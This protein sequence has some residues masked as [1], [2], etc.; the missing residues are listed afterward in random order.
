MS[1]ACG[2]SHSSIPTGRFVPEAQAVSATEA[3]SRQ[4]LM[5]SNM[6][7]DLVCIG[8]SPPLILLLAPSALL[9]RPLGCI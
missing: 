3:V 1:L 6:L 7:I 8:L 5:L 4:P 2:L 9:R